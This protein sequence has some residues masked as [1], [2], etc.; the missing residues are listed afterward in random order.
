M[1][2]EAWLDTE[3]TG[4]WGALYDL[5]AYLHEGLV[6]DCR[7]GKLVCKAPCVDVKHGAERAEEVL[8][9]RWGSVWLANQVL[10]VSDSTEERH[11]LFSAYL[12]LLDGIV[13]RL[14]IRKIEPWQYGIEG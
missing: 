3:I 12:V 6:R 10:L 1:G 14:T 8:C 7:E 9:M 5:D 2:G 11:F 4:H 13:H